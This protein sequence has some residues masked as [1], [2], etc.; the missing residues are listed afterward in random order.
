MGQLPER[1]N[2]LEQMLQQM[3][4]E[5]H[6]LKEEVQNLE[7]EN[8]RLRREVAGIYLEQDRE[9]GVAVPARREGLENLVRL[10]DQGFHVCNLHFGQ[11]RTGECLFCSTFLRRGELHG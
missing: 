2:A 8:A 6:K 3:L 11:A 5:L 9:A 4:G 1:I 7:D 10:Y